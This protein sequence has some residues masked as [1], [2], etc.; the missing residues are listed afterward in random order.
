MN[1]WKSLAIVG[2]FAFFHHLW[3]PRSPY[4]WPSITAGQ[5]NRWQPFSV[6][7]FCSLPF[8]LC[9]TML[10]L[11]LFLSLWCCCSM[12]VCCYHAVS[13]SL[14]P[15]FSGTKAL[16]SVLVFSWRISS[17][18]GIMVRSPR[19]HVTWITEDEFR[20]GKEF[21]SSGRVWC[22]QISWEDIL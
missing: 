2:T 11:L 4:Q 8:L 21:F 7:V 15:T 19:S 5:S 12:A 16:L 17:L 1:S 10:L 13:A 14:S 6:F 18:L 9:C 3:R 22:K 20:D